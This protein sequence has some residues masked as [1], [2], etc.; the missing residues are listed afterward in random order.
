V[1]GPRAVAHRL[2][3]F[4]AVA[5]AA[6]DARIDAFLNATAAA[7]PAAAAPT[8]T[9]GPATNTATAAPADAGRGPTAAVAGPNAVVRPGDSAR[10]A[11][12]GPELRP[13]SPLCADADD[14]GR[15]HEG[16][17]HMAAAERPPKRQAKIKAHLRCAS[18][19]VLRRVITTK[20]E[21]RWVVF[22]SLSL[23]PSPPWS[24]K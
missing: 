23:S 13:G 7:A 24:K 8:E 16:V 1:V 11:D 5:D 18:A 22:I 17:A 4:G 19:N 6:A 10:V 21:R 14:A 12:E 3:A 9:T 20:K 2:A 15:M